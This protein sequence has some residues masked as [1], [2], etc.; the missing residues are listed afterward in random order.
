VNGCLKLLL[1]AG[2]GAVQLALFGSFQQSIRYLILSF[3]TAAGTAVVAMKFWLVSG[4]LDATTLRWA[5][6]VVGLWGHVRD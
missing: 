5:A 4:A 2:L 6:A 1:R 3:G